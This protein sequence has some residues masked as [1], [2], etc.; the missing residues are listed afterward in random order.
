M[1][2]LT[3]FFGE[4]DSALGVFYPTGCIIAVFPTF[5][6]A[7][8]AGQALRRIGL[9]SD[10]FLALRGAE[11]LEFFKEFRAHSG[12]WA[13]VMAMLS[14]AFGTEQVFADF[15]VRCARAGE[16]FLAIHSPDETQ[17]KHIQ[18]LLTQY[19]PDAMHYYRSGGVENLV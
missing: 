18:E 12:L 3:N 6:T 10:D 8:A 4:S 15:D 2:T 17:T 11:V 16:G 13:G 19:Q 9:G 14:R 5:A 1:T 7:E